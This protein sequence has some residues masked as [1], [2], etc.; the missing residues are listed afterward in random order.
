MTVTA[1]KTVCREHGCGRPRGTTASGLE[2]LFCDHHI[3][4][5]AARLAQFVADHP[6]SVDGAYRET[7]RALPPRAPVFLPPTPEEG[8]CA[9]CGEYPPQAG[10]RL[11]ED[12]RGG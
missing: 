9:R 12:C 2:S 7:V 10:D 11:C 3:D 6:T 1:P 5:K 4:L 8:L